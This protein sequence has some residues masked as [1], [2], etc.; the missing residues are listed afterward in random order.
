MS[1]ALPV[2]DDIAAVL[3]A[4]DDI[5]SHDL[6]DAEH[7]AAYEFILDAQEGA[8]QDDNGD[9]VYDCDSGWVTFVDGK[10]E[11]DYHMTT[12]DECE[13]FCEY[14]FDAMPGGLCA[15]CAEQ[16][17]EDEEKRANGWCSDCHRKVCD[18]AREPE[19]VYYDGDGDCYH[20]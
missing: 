3:N 15:D 19:E 14:D 12:C 1:N 2:A 13:H 16:Q 20:Y 4:W 9:S 10:W 6:T 7:E 11:A 17:E 5:E 8:E 18:C